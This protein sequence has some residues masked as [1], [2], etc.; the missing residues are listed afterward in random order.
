MFQPGVEHWR[1][2]G[3]VVLKSRVVSLPI[4]WQLEKCQVSQVN[5][6]GNGWILSWINSFVGTV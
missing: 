2:I 1:G 3:D 4:H 5:E 6:L